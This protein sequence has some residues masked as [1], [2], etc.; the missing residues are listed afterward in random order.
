[1]IKGDVGIIKDQK[2][3]NKGKEKGLRIPSIV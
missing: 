1:M 3:K 2:A